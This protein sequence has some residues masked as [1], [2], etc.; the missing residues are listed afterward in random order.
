MEITYK[1][2]VSGAIGLL[3]HDLAQQLLSY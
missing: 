2:W 3:A 1:S